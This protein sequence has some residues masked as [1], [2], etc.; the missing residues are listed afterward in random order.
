MLGL[1]DRP[2]SGTYHLAGYDVTKLSDGQMALVRNRLIGFVFQQFHLLPR[3]SALENAGLPL[4]YASIYNHA[5]AQE[6]L[7]AVGLADRMDH[8]SNELSGGQ[9]Q[10]V[11]IARAL[12]NEPILLMADEPTGNLDSKSKD[13]IMAILKGLNEQGKTIVMVTHEPDM[14]AYASRVLVMKDGQIISD[15]PQ[16]VKK[17]PSVAK[18]STTDW[19]FIDQTV[20]SIYDAAKWI[21]SFKQAIYAMLSHKLRSLL[22]ILGILIGVA[23]VIAMLALGQ[24]AQESLQAQ[25][26][27]LGSNLLMVRPGTL[28]TGG[29]TLQ[30]GLVTRLN[31]AD[32]K[33]VKQLSGDVQRVSGTVSG[34]AQIV[35]GSKNWNTEVDGVDVDYADMRAFRPQ[36]GR[37][38]LEVK[39]HW[40]KRLK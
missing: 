13:E 14:A 2:D 18:T 23:A 31:F 11:A 6:K 25:L 28:T 38:F 34:H 10:R 24:G 17:A 22:S 20:S 40:V 12:V 15:L 33:A 27:S 4:V 26:S 37:F 35:A 29:V 39:I 8:K 7:Q 3:M 1:L 36:I 30:A 5:K 19:S 32:V 21:D 16:Q 9:Q